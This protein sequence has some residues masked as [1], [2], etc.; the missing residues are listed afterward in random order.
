MGTIL[1]GSVPGVWIGTALVDRVPVGVPAARARLRAARL[2]ARRADEGRRSTCRRGRSSGIAAGGRRCSRWLRRI[3]SQ[4][5][6]AAGGGM[7]HARADPPATSSRPRRSTSCA[8]SRPSSRKPVLLFSGGK[9]SIVLLRLAEK[10]FRPAPLPVPAHARRHGPQLPR[11]HRVPRPPRRRAR[12]AADRRL[13]AGVDRPRPRRRGDRPAR[14][15]QP[16]ADD[17]AARRDRGAR[18]RRRVRRRAP[19]RGARPREGADLLASATTSA[20]GTRAASA[21]S[22]GASTTGA[23]AAASTCACSRSSNWTELDVWQYIAKERLEVPSIYF[24][25]EREVF[26]RDGMLYAVSDHVELHRRR[27]AVHRDA[28]ATAR[29]AT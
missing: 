15:A 5:R 4:F 3:G 13:R 23:S 19:R 7:A 2:G 25:H 11:G 20:S 28:C 18:L 21:R 17:D 1:L 8:R 24:A 9:D 16:A 29:S 26:R 22:C 12:R 6:K 14:V 27:G 10:A